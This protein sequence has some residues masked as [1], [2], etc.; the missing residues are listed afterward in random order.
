MKRLVRSQ[1]AHHFVDSTTS[2]SID[3]AI[4]AL[5]GTGKRLANALGAG[6]RALE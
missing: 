1:A 3:E 5:R 6:V 2:G 4:V